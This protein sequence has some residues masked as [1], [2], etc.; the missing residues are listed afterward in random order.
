MRPTDSLIVCLL[1]IL[2]T[3]LTSCNEAP[4]KKRQAEDI[5]H[6]FQ[7]G[8]NVA[9]HLITES[10]CTVLLPLPVGIM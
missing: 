2:A 7:K 1:L 8:L 4:N 6:F 9:V 5:T 3:T 10:S